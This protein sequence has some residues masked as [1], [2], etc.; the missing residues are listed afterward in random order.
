M[1]CEPSG[2]PSSAISDA[3]DVSAARASTCSSPDSGWSDTYRPS[4]SRSKASRCF[5]SQ[6][7]RSGTSTANVIAASSSAPPKPAKRSN[8]PS[9]SLRFTEMTES[10]ACSCTTSRARRGWPSESNAPALMSDS[11]VRLLQTT[12]GT[13]SRKSVKDVNAPFSSRAAMIASTTLAPTLRIAVRPKRMSSPTAVNL[14][15]ESLT[16]GGSTVMCMRRHSPR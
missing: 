7:G 12:A 4:I 15:A 2:R 8:W 9:A 16:S 10:T 1:T 13:L 14:A 3:I 11:M 6:S 5:L